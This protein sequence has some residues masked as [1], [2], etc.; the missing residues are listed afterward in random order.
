MNGTNYEVLRKFLVLEIF[1]FKQLTA[2]ITR[3]NNEDIPAEGVYLKI[4]NLHHTTFRLTTTTYIIQQSLIKFMH[5]FIIMAV[6][7]VLYSQ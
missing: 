3:K 1:I 6:I 2:V 4:K 7:K 5:S